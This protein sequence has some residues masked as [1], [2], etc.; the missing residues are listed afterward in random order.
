MMDGSE[1]IAKVYLE[2]LGLGPV[3]YEPNG[4]IPPDF[5]IGDIGVEVRRLN[6]NFESEGGYEGLESVEASVL[7]YVEKLLPTYGPPKDG[8]GWWVSLTFWR[9]L[10]GKA[11]KRELPRVLAAFY[12]HPNPAGLD[13]KLARNFELEIRPAS[14]TVANHFM[15]GAS[16]DFD[17]GGFIASEIIRNLN[18]CITEKAA[19][20][21]TY[22]DRYR[23]WWLVL[24]DYIGPDLNADERSTI[25]EH[26]NT[27]TFSRVVLIH[28]RDPTK[29]LVMTQQRV[30]PNPSN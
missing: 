2:S 5:M 8:Q 14:I 21:A 20:I 24:P 16:S 26:V 7:R 19:K 3:V 23:E 15:L 9:P 13:T 11:I 27:L 10:D 29:A 28:P 18:L 6:Q 12:A 30:K 17:Q 1:E 22:K 4:Q 25:G